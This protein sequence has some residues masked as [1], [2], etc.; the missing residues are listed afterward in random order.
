MQE[1][2][3]VYPV[4]ARGGTRLIRI[5]S[6]CLN[7]PG[8]LSEVISSC[9]HMTPDRGRPGTNDGTQERGVLIVRT[10]QGSSSS[11]VLCPCLEPGDFSPMQ[12]DST[13]VTKEGNMVAD[14]GPMLRALRTEIS[15]SAWVLPAFTSGSVTWLSPC[16]FCVPRAPSW[17]PSTEPLSTA[18]SE[19]N[20]GLQ[21]LVLPSPPGLLPPALCFVFPSLDHAA[22]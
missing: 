21:P 13:A 1:L 22:F 11:W 10:L 4:R 7:S 6:R 18:F 17:L 19:R 2:V 20:E 12:T 14:Q 3:L 5:G 15:R 8:H 16:F 9:S